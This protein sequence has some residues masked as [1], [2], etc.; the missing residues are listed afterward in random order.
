MSGSHSRLRPLTL[1]SC[2][3]RLSPDVR[4][5]RLA[6]SSRGSPQRWAE[7]EVETRLLTQIEVR[8]GKTLIAR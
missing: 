5:L 3:R 4:Q 6:G 1:R 8:C 2:L 7:V